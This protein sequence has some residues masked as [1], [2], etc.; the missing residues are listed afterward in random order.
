MLAP[1]PSQV[2]ETAPITNENT[3]PALPKSSLDS[4]KAPV[5]FNGLTRLKI[6]S[7]PTVGKLFSSISS[8]I[9]RRTKLL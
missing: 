4:H 5:V 3:Q 1:K 2:P 9:C 7:A 8:L 6:L